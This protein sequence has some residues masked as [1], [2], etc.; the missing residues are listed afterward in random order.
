MEN[1]R[2]DSLPEF[3]TSYIDRLLSADQPSVKKEAPRQPAEV[4]EPQP[5]QP[6]EA[7]PANPSA[8]P[9]RI[10]LLLLLGSALICLLVGFLLGRLTAPKPQ[11]DPTDPIHTTSTVPPDNTLTLPDG[12]GYIPNYAAMSTKQL[13]DIA[14]QIPELK[15]LGSP[16]VSMQLTPAIC[17]ELKAANPVLIELEQRPDAVEQLTFY[18]LVSSSLYGNPAATAL[19]EY[20]VNYLGFDRYPP[21]DE[22]VPDCEWVL[23]DSDLFTVYEY[24]EA[25]SVYFIMDE[26]GSGVTTVFDFDGCEFY[27]L[28]NMVAPADNANFW[29]RMELTPEGFGFAS[30]PDP[31]PELTW[32]SPSSSTWVT[33][34][35]SD[36][37]WF[38]YGYTPSK[39][40]LTFTVYP[41]GNARTVNLTVL[42]VPASG[43]PADIAQCV[44]DQALTLQ[45]LSLKNPEKDL[46]TYPIVEAVLAQPLGISALLNLAQTTEANVTFDPSLSVNVLVPLLT[47]STF[48]DRMTTNEAAALQ[49]LRGD[50][51][52]YLDL[53][54]LSRITVWEMPESFALPD[55]PNY[56]IGDK[57]ESL[58]GIPVSEMDY[59]VY[60]PLTESAMLLRQPNWEL[61]IQL[62]PGAEGQFGAWPVYNADDQIMG[63]IVS[64]KRENHYS[65]LLSL[66]QGDTELASQSLDIQPLNP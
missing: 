25:P 14:I 6:E 63:W 1:D 42:P 61:E 5:A 26:G 51:N 49:L 24:M 4:E 30:V 35:K 2:H 17:E 18:N 65:L 48:S 60:V 15:A 9:K 55:L 13:T 66:V 34:Q 29:Y 52:V 38:I 3:D 11:T 31:E 28:G 53:Y 58:S 12:G 57:P 47:M 46:A 50:S 8:P 16:T 33:W 37:G 39:A 54:D 43:E 56:R 20:Y 40:D 36:Q 10:R 19:I 21:V 45:A 64:G 44:L 41:S 23:Q 27:L 22:V 7:A 59:R 62:A 32:F